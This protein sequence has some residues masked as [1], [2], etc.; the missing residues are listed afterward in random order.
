MNDNKETLEA[1]NPNPLKPL[2]K[3]ASK[4]TKQKNINCIAVRFIIS[5]YSI[6]KIK[7]CYDISYI[8]LI[9]MI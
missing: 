1:E 9:K 8:K 4:I 5:K 3:E 6:E 7:K 2:T